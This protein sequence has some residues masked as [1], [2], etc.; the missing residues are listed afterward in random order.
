VQLVKAEASANGPAAETVITRLS[1]ILF[2]QAVRDY[3]RTADNGNGGW[4]NALKDP[5][6]GQALALIHRQPGESWSVESLAS[7]VSLSRSAFSAKFKELV[8]ESPMQYVTRVRLTKAAAMLRTRPSTLIEVALSIG[9]DSEVAF[10]KA[11]KRY[12][13]IAPGAYRLGERQ[14]LVPMRRADGSDPT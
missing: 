9:Y 14:H 12:F 13:N 1:E 7:R 3:M 11:F 10:S 5:Q 6:I 2:I 8:G 4:F